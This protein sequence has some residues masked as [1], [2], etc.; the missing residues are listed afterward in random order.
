MRF[1]LQSCKLRQAPCTRTKTPTKLATK[2][3]RI[4]RPRAARAYGEGV[5]T[6]RR[7]HK[8]EPETRRDDSTPPPINTTH[9]LRDLYPRERDPRPVNARQLHASLTLL[10][11]SGARFAAGARPAAVLTSWCA[12]N[13]LVTEEDGDMGGP[14]GATRRCSPSLACSYVVKSVTRLSDLTKQ[15]SCA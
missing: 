9:P 1:S 14:F 2:R 10:C 15:C 12:H 8:E 4:Q 3:T 6:R 5:C 7:R 13:L 11:V